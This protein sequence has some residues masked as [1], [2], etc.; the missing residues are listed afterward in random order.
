MDA[1][2]RFLRRPGTR[3]QMPAPVDPR[4]LDA[5]PAPPRRPWRLRRVGFQRGSG[6]DDHSIGIIDG[7]DGVRLKGWY[8]GRVA[9]EECNRFEL[10][11]DGVSLGF[12]DAAE[13]RQDVLM[14]E[15]KLECGFTHDI[16]LLAKRLPEGAAVLGDGQSHRFT[17]LSVT[18]KR[19][20]EVVLAGKPPV[21]GQFDRLETKAMSGWAINELDPGQPV[22]LEVLLDGRHWLDVKTSLLRKDLLARGMAGEAAGFRVEWPEGMLPGDARV[23]VRARGSSEALDKGVRVVPADDR[24]ATVES[25]YLAHHREGRILPVTVIVPI[26]NAVH[27]V[28]ECLASLDRHLG[29]DAEVLLLDDASTDP[30]IDEL[31]RRYEDKPAFRVHRNTCNLGYTR[32]INLGSSLC[33]GRDVVLLNSDTVVTERWLESLRY[34]AYARSR[35]ATVTALSDNAGAFSVPE[36]GQANPLPAHLDAEGWGRLARNASAGRLPEVP[37][38][39]GF[40]MYLRREA[41]DAIGAFDEGKFPR[42]YGEENDFCMRAL[43]KGWRNLVCDKAYVAHKRSQSFQEEKTTLMEAGRKQL[44]V[45]FPEYGMLVRRFRDPEFSYLRHRVR[46]A[47]QGEAGQVA[48]RRVLYVISTQTGGT[49]QTNLDLMRAM[50]GHYH[51][52]LLR[53]DA[54]SIRLHELRDGDLVELEHWR[55]SRPIEPVSHRSDEYDAIVLD[56]LYRHSISLLHVRHVAWHGLGLASAAKSIGVPVVYSLHDFYSLCPSLNLIDENL[57]YCG[58]R[59]T[60]GSGTCQVSLWKREQL[61]PLKHAFVGRWRE[62]FDGFMDDCDQLIT[63][64]ASAAEVISSA[65]PRQAGKLVV[66]PHGRDFDEL[67]VGGRYPGRGAKVRVLVP[68]NISPSKGAVLL[69]AIAELDGGARFEFHFLGNVWPGLDGVGIRHGSY[70][71]EDFTSKVAAIAPHFGV[72]FSIWP[73]TWCHT[74]TEMWACG[75]PVMGID[76]GAVGERIR[77]SGAGWLLRPDATPAATLDF[78][79]AVVEDA[80][81]FQRRVRAV[82]DWQ[83]SEAVCNDTRSMA[84]E[85]RRAYSRLL[86]M[87]PTGAGRRIGLLVKGNEQH[88]PTAHIRVLRPFTAAATKAGHELRTVDAGWLLAGGIDRLDGLVIQR[89]AVPGTLMGPLLERLEARQVPFIYEIDD[90][91]WD[92]PDDHGDHDIDTAQKSA[93]MSA[94][95]AADLVTTSTSAMRARLERYNANVRVLANAPDPALWLSPIAVEQATRILALHGLQAAMPRVLYMGSRSHASDLQM[96]APAVAAF[97]AGHPGVEV[98]QVGGGTLLPGARELKVP[99]EY[100]TYPQFVSWFH[101]VASAMTF[102]LAPL[103][104]TPFNAVKS[105]VKFL[106]YALAQVPGI[107]SAIDPY[108]RSLADGSHGLVVKKEQQAWVGAMSRLASDQL[109]RAQIRQQA[110]QLAVSRTLAGSGSAPWLQ[111]LDDLVDPDPAQR[112]EARRSAA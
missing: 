88:P 35:V 29:R 57:R 110:F 19:V 92:L 104:D 21:R 50:D 63:T 42:G 38:G 71:R 76:V 9:G 12:V 69:K 68:G 60:Q 109:L 65:F 24:H 13:P 11:L 105:D 97:L 112:T 41:I 107:Y 52:L 59:C 3:A 48:L 87:L 15:G 86:D 66:I 37:T 53:C 31:L 89:D 49:P 73:E 108:E 44:D 72:V 91:L 32:T 22:E 55:L 96:I 39:N 77:T 70:K 106:D 62:M 33:P 51:C 2:R 85:Y 67:T 94:I 10:R 25:L 28:S 14:A 23:E 90:L 27:A 102:A 101:V 64:A 5:I 93:I 98:I 16:R 46:G 36:I 80:A 1:K 95:R 99:R 45:D 74:L 100:S 103:R 17:M 83:A 75:I 78:M 34:A 26:Y 47:L 111:A 84:I 58:G 82:Q 61:P 4:T 40:C 7:L 79:R 54:H 6:R 18:G 30:G 81:G 56:I 43:R 8:I 20:H